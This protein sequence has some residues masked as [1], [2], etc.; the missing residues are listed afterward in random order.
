M[1]KTETAKCDTCRQTIERIPATSAWN[2]E[3]WRHTRAT[4]HPAKPIR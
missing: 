4:N 1:T 3:Y 2:T